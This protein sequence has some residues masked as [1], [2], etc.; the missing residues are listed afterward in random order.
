MNQDDVRVLVEKN[1]SLLAGGRITQD[2]YNKN[3]Q[4]IIHAFMQEVH[5]DAS[6]LI[7][8]SSAPPTGSKTPEPVK[9]PVVEIPSTKSKPQVARSKSLPVI[10]ASQTKFSLSRNP[11]LKPSHPSHQEKTLKFQRVLLNQ[12]HQKISR[13]QFQDIHLKNQL[14]HLL[15]SELFPVMNL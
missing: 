10:I 15:L 7:G 4:S 5:L 9:T 1:N 12:D 2:E 11:N 8:Y 13:R 3:K 14:E 6:K